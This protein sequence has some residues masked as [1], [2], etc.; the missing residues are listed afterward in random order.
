VQLYFRIIKFKTNWVQKGFTQY[1]ISLE[2]E[3]QMFILK[4]CWISLL[5]QWMYN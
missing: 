5:Q 1:P 2:N 3:E 4:L